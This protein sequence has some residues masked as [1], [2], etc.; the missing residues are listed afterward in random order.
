MAKLFPAK[1]AS[2]SA[3]VFQPNEDVRLLSARLHLAEERYVDLRKKLQFIEQNMLSFQKKMHKELKILNDEL[4]EIKRVQHEVE[5]KIILL[6]KEIQLL[7]SKEDVDVIQK[8][9]QYWDPVR[10]A[11]VEQVEKM[12]DE[13]LG[14]TEQRKL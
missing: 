13:R 8:Y 3:P 2:E 11:T 9:L 7:A 1:P 5:S 10:F 14:N 12:L 4:A 6:I